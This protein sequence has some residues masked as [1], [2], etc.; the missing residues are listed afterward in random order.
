MTLS[1]TEEAERLTRKRARVLPVLAILLISQQAVYFNR[2]G[3]HG[4][5]ELKI[6][7]WLVLALVLLAGLATG[8]AW[9][10][11]RDVRELINDETTREHRRRSYSTGF[12]AAM[13]VAV[14]LYVVDMFD[15]VSGRDSIHIIM[16]AAIGTALL[17]FGNLERRALRDG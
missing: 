12:W 7:A 11:R 14:G 1:V 3:S 2:S 6:A 4:A 17:T 10:S 9:F 8:G 15:P 13:G 5:Q 16:T